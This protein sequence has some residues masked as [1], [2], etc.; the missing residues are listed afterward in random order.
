MCFSASYMFYYFCQWPRNHLRQPRVKPFH[1]PSSTSMCLF[2]PFF[3]LLVSSPLLS[4]YFPWPQGAV[5]YLDAGALLWALIDCLSLLPTSSQASQHGAR[6][7]CLICHCSVNVLC[8]KTEEQW[9]ARLSGR[10][11]I[12]G[13]PS[14]QKPAVISSVFCPSPFLSLCS[15]FFSQ[16]ETI[17]G[18]LNQTSLV[19]F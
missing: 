11:F 5:S 16:P 12:K 19:L 2:P 15:L 4:T 3:P 6:A 18:V 13:C 1:P 8:E 7:V 17:N 9:R 14:L 10:A